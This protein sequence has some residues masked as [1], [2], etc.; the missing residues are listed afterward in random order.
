MHLIKIISTLCATFILF[1]MAG[2]ASGTKITRAKESAPPPAIIAE[3]P[4]DSDAYYYYMRSESRRI[5]GDLKGAM[6][7][8]EMAI[9]YDSAS[10]YLRTRLALIYLRT[11]NIE[12]AIKTAE[13]ARKLDPAFI[14]AHKLLAALY[15]SSNRPAEAVSEYEKLMEI[16][17]EDEE[18]Y[19]YLGILYS[20]SKEYEKAID[21]LDRLLKV[22]PGSIM[23]FYYMGKVHSEMKLYSQAIK[24]Y[25]KVLELKPNFQ[26]ALFDI[27]TIYEIT[28]EHQQ[29]VSMYK[30]ILSIY[31]DDQRAQDRLGNLYVKGDM[32]DDALKQFLELQLSTDNSAIRLKI[33][34]IYLEQM[35]Y[36]KAIEEFQLV[37]AEEPDNE[38]ALYYLGTAYLEIKDISIASETF[39]KIPTTSRFYA[40]SVIN[41]AYALRTAGR[42]DEAVKQIEE[43]IGEVS[44]GNQLRLVLSSL[45]AD[46]KQYQ[47]GIDILVEMAGKEPDN[48]NIHFK[49]GMLYDNAGLK[50]DGIRVMKRVLELNPLH[51]DAMNYLGYTYAEKGIHLDEAEALATKAM[52][53]RPNDGYITDSLGW[54][55]F[56]KGNFKEAVMFL[57]KATILSP[58]DPVIME[59]LG[60]AYVKIGDKEKAGEFYNKSHGL[61]KDEKEK[62]KLLKKIKDLAKGGGDG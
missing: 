60:D 19:L 12:L 61:Q 33:G 22:N 40:E 29:A 13:E 53:L 34:I 7:D 38:M 9:K 3:T 1:V 14:E 41:L 10:P 23:A 50:D 26:G 28:G 62:E 39:K 56:K 15:S 21:T 43:A 17:P 37:L 36:E 11:G 4:A 27:A 20:R 16:K 18:V 51:A 55:H 31:P 8:L 46:L 49:L 44:N 58:E 35:K 57:E 45:Y 42:G 24:D 2:C 32:L 6:A 5:D 54:V 52:E 59:H 25:E 30:K 48:D 47:K